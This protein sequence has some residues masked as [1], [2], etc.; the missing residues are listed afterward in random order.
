MAEAVERRGRC[1][2]GA[3]R[4]RV[5][6]EPIWVAHCH[7]DS[8]RRAS[9]AALVTW[10][11]FRRPDFAFTAGE[12]AA[13]R[14]SPGVVRRFCPRCGSPLTYESL[15]WPEET[16]VQV[17]SFDDPTAFQPTRHVHVAEQLPWLHLADGLERN[18]GS[19]A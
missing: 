9:S 11:G 4:Y 10:A 18:P 15:R 7:C 19:G 16:H 6:G 8:C 14:S 5:T 13:Y 3:V 1:L 12:P 17:C 2:C